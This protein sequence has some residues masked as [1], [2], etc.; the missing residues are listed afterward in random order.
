MPPFPLSNTTCLDSNNKEQSQSNFKRSVPKS[1]EK[2]RQHNSIIHLCQQTWDT[3]IC[4]HVIEEP[5]I[6]IAPTSFNTKLLQ[7]LSSITGNPHLKKKATQKE[8]GK[9]YSS[10][11]FE[12][13]N[14]FKEIE[15][16][17]GHF[18]LNKNSSKKSHTFR[19]CGLFSTEKLTFQL[20]KLNLDSE[21]IKKSSLS[22]T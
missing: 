4:P 21:D 11:Y 6:I 3:R 19:I 14:F 16:L 5:Q 22:P 12:T 1:G 20:F 7:K 13:I 10:C 15:F 2:E 18:H 9:S 8:K 17:K